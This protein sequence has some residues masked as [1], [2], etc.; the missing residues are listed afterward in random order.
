MRNM[1]YKAWFI[2][3]LV[4]LLAGIVLLCFS[5]F[6]DRS[7]PGSNWYLTAAMGCTIVANVLNMIRGVRLRR[8]K[9]GQDQEE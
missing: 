2:A 1:K 7:A 6:G 8:E 5:I 3:A 4:F 9:D